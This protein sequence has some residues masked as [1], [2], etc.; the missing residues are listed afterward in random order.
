MILKMVQTPWYPFCTT[1]PFLD[2][3]NVYL[4]EYD[5]Y[6]VF[7][8]GFKQSSYYLLLRQKNPLVTGFVKFYIQD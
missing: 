6:Y 1:K 2:E 7:F 3:N 5:H 4:N 8:I